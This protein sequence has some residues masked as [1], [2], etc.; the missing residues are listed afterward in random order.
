MMAPR[1]SFRHIRKVKGG[2]AKKGLTAKQ[3]LMLAA[4]A[5]GAGGAG[6]AATRK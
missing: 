4:A 1:G 5:A 3:K 2:A 6:Y